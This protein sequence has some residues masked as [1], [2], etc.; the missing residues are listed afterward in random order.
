MRGA[1]VIYNLQTDNLYLQF[2]ES[3]SFLFWVSGK[4]RLLCANF[5]HYFTVERMYTGNIH[6][7]SNF[8]DLTGYYFY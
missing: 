4:K 7:K 3:I 5:K 6:T 1:K 2:T 8:T